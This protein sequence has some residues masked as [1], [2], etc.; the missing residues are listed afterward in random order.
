MGHNEHNVHNIDKDLSS[1]SVK[2]EAGKDVVPVS[3]LTKKVGTEPVTN[4]TIIPKIHRHI[5]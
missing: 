4:R 1:V 5:Y 3:T 2:R